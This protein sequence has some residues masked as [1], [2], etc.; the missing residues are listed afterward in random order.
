MSTEQA[1]PA[2]EASVEDRLASFFGGGEVTPKE[3]PEPQEQEVLS[4][5]EPAEV[6][7]AVAED[8]GFDWTAD[9]GEVIKVPSKAKD[10]LLR[11]DDYTRKTQ[12]VA[13]LAQA[14]QDRL[15]YAEAREQIMSAVLEDVGKLNVLQADLKRYQDADWSAI[16]SADPGQAFKLQ[17]QMRD[18]E[19]Q[20]NEQQGV[21]RSKADNLQKASSDHAN[22]QWQLAEEG[23]RRRIGN[24]TQEDNLAM[25][26]AVRELGFDEKEFKTRFADPRIIHAVYKA[27]KWD[28]LQ[29]GKPAA[30]QKAGAAPPVIKP[31]AAQPGAAAERGLKDARQQ[32]R[33]TG[34]IKDA[35]ALLMRMK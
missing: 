26:R 22:K 28:A 17:Q 2:S 18:L 11:R 13:G 21:I 6:E 9:D 5:D 7:T 33:K 16:Y 25:A 1:A 19:R 3:E 14:A 15:Q 30:V 20:I 4:Q 31:G 34:S 29:S 8:V 10:A 23:V 32:L 12:E 35:A 24:I 27:A